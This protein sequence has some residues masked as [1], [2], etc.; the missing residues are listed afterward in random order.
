[1]EQAGGQRAGD[2]TGQRGG[3]PDPRVLDDVAHLQHAGA[4]ALAYQA[5]HTVLAVAH[6]GKA[7][8]LGAA[9]RHGGTSGQTRQAQGR[10]DGGGGDGQGQRHAHDDRDEDAHDERSLLGGPH[11]EGAHLAGRRADGGG[12]QHGEA[13]ARKD[14]DQRGDK[15]VD[16]GLLAHGLAQ[17][18]RHNGDDEDSQRA[19]GSAQRVGGVA[20]RDQAEQHQR[21]AVECPADGDG[22]GRAA[23]GRGIAA[24]VHQHVQPGLLAQCF[25]D[26]ADEQAG[27]QALRHGTQRLNEVA[28][29]GNDDVFSS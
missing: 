24:Q 5:A 1:M 22:H 14:R 26:G 27:K 18:C 21:R 16:P 25:D 13:D 20:Y 12:D 3:D 29:R 10:A 28:L 2:G 17:L 6:H 4:Q 23:H 15:N 9:A 7:H 11:D 8:H 19:A